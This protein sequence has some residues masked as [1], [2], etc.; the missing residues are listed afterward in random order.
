MLHMFGMMPS[1]EVKIEKTIYLDTDP[2]SLDKVRIQAGENGW[3]IIWADRSTSYQDISGT[4]ESNFDNAM[5][6]LKEKFPNAR[7]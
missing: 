5:R 2:K 7:I 1:S 4:V 6:V 3:T